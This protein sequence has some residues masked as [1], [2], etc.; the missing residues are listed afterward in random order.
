MPATLQ[1]IVADQF[2]IY[3]LKSDG[4]LWVCSTREPL[5]WNTLPVFSGSGAQI[6]SIALARTS[7]SDSTLSLYCN[8]SDGTLWRLL[9]SGSWYKENTP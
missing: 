7:P 9:T 5:Q 2:R 3:G 8:A 1:T 4:S 6:A